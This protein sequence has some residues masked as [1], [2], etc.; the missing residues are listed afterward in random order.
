MSTY[1]LQPCPNPP[2]Q[3]KV[4]LLDRTRGVFMILT[5]SVHSDR[6]GLHDGK[7]LTLVTKPLHTWVEKNLQLLEVED[8]Q[9][10]VPF[11]VWASDSSFAAAL[12]ETLVNVAGGNN[13]LAQKVKTSISVMQLTVVALVVGFALPGSRETVKRAVYQTVSRAQ[14]ISQIPRKPACSLH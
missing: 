11:A 4:V 7:C 13:Q 10:C 14:R 9:V 12:H 2:P 5:C 3:R 6:P 8:D 1:D